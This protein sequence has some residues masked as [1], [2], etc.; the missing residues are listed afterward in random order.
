MKKYT[1]KTNRKTRRKNI[2]RKYSKK[3][4]GGVFSIIDIANWRTIEKMINS[5]GANLEVISYSSLSGFIFKL[6]IPP[7]VNTDFRQFNRTPI[8]SLI[9][10]IA[11]I[12]KTPIYKIYTNLFKQKF[13]KKTETRKDFEKEFTMQNDIYYKTL[14]L[15]GINICPS[16]IDLSFLD[17]DEGRKFIDNLANISGSKKDNECIKMLSFLYKNMNKDTQLGVI[18]ME[19][20]SDIQYATLN[21][22][23]FDDDTYAYNN[24]YALA[25]IVILF[26]NFK[27]INYDS[28]N[29]NIFGSVDAQKQPLLIDFGKTII[30]KDYNDSALKDLYDKFFHNKET[31]VINTQPNNESDLFIDVSTIIDDIQTR[32]DDIPTNIDNDD[33]PIKTDNNNFRNFNKD[34]SEIANI[35][36]SYFYDIN[37]NNKQEKKTTLEKIIR[38]I[39]YMDY[40]K[41][42]AITNRM[43]RYPQ[44]IS[45]LKVLYGR[46]ISD[47]WYNYEFPPDLTTNEQKQA[48][49]DT[50]YRL[51]NFN[52]QNFNILN[53]NWE[54]GDTNFEFICS[55]IE[56]ITKQVKSPI[57]KGNVRQILGFNPRSK[58]YYPTEKNFNSL[59][60]PIK[61]IPMSSLNTPED[62]PRKK[63][64]IKRSPSDPNIQNTDEEALV[65]KRSASDNR[66]FNIYE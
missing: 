61:P 11:M 52:R 62:K 28:H 15:N 8:S 26:M 34:F 46:N 32:M 36:A 12:S 17:E 53:F 45:L 19:F 27:I 4:K 23:I 43:L 49:F 47:S 6:N 3:M 16:V 1:R 41:N 13:S 51:N 57:F 20:I 31:F 38:F 37:A 29:G 58:S 54:M 66:D 33:I 14:E 59:I 55:K 2:R 25:E 10:K 56:D 9:F 44:F 35:N 50:H 64:T 63:T 7:N 48:Y 21:E 22:R 5:Q 40:L 39:A 18:T 30:L 42:C 60:S 24:L 65:F